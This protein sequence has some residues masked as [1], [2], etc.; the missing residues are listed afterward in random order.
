[1]KMRMTAWKKTHRSSF[2]QM[3]NWL[4]AA[5][6]ILFFGIEALA[7]VLNVPSD[8]PT[9]QEALDAASRGDTVKVGPGIY[10]ENV[11]I[12][13]PLVLWGSGSS[14][15]TIDGSGIDMVVRVEADSCL[16]KGFLVQN[17]GVN[18]PTGVGVYIFGDDAVIEEM[19]VSNTRMGVEIQAPHQN[20]VVR[21]NLFSDNSFGIWLHYRTNGTLITGNTV[22]GKYDYGVCLAN[23][24]FNRIENNRI[25]N[26]RSGIRLR[27]SDNNIIQGNILDGIGRMGI[28]L[29]YSDSNLVLKNRFYGMGTGWGWG[30]FLGER[31]ISN[32][33]SE[34]FLSDHDI[35]IWVYRDS[36]D[37]I[38]CENTIV[39]NRYGLVL[40]EVETNM[41]FHNNFV[42]NELQVFDLSPSLNDWYHPILLEGN[43]WSDYDGVDDGSGSGKH[44]IAG[45]GIGDTDIPHPGAN[46]D[47]YPFM[48]RNGWRPPKSTKKD[49]L[50]ELAGLMES[51]T[52]PKV[53]KHIKHAFQELEKT[54]PYFSDN[55]HIT[56]ASRVFD[57]EKKVTKEV[58]KSSRSAKK[59]EIPDFE[60]VIS[61]LREIALYMVEAD[62]LLAGKAIREAEAYPEAKQK[63]IKKAK[64]E[65]TKAYAELSK[66]DKSM[67]KLGIE[68]YKYDKAINHFK[69]AYEHAHKAVKKKHVL[70]AATASSPPFV[71]MSAVGPNPFHETTAIRYQLSGAGKTIPVCLNIYDLTGRVIRTLVDERQDPGEYTVQWR[72][73]D[74]DGRQVAGGVY[75]YRLTAG[76]LVSTK[77][78][79]LMR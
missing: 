20:T 47:F 39:N 44:S 59:Y 9:I 31:S 40:D 52:H 3:S 70:L 38:I 22:L 50:D 27:R 75:F 10:Y 12:P 76:D 35:G 24:D 1:M 32:V 71:L 51:I 28:H 6:V 69:H 77:K 34:N 8:Y 62:S 67:K 18:D 72:G 37:G 57:R 46:Y 43:F 19:Q 36:R 61:D 45:D 79:V 65:M 7:S 49:A 4:L 64:K 29:S 74:R 2:S 33:I 17:S 42:E 54:L 78:M 14:S 55:W 13:K 73:K 25:S 30:L 56:K 21:N 63:E 41:V 11:R 58:R 15:T 16:V 5:S 66:I 53:H 68:W 26:G 60:E 23:T 48:E